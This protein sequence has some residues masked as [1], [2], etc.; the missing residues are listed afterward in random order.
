MTQSF[1][2]ASEGAKRI[3]AE[4]ILTS[5]G[6]VHQQKVRIIGG[7]EIPPYDYIYFGYTGSDIT[8][9]IYKTGGASGTTLAT[10]T[11]AYSGSNIS[12]ITKS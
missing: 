10:L 3:D 1:L 7:F 4:E 9:V 5:V 6:A 8:S 2:P 12:S 11:L